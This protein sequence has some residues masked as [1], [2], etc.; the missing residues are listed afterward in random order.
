MFNHEIREGVKKL[1]HGM[2]RNACESSTHKSH[3]GIR[4]YRILTGQRALLYSPLISKA[5]NFR[6]N[7]ADLLPLRHYSTNSNDDI[8][9]PSLTDFPVKFH[10][11]FFTGINNILVTYLGIKP[12]LDSSFSG[13]EFLSTTKKV[14]TRKTRS[15]VNSKLLRFNVHHLQMIN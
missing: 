11:G 8:D 2:C 13:F 1:Y 7:S 3:P 10:P 9:I 6:F 15:I 5:T 4:T 12:N 14:R